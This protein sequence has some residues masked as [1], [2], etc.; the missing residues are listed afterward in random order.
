MRTEQVQEV[1]NE[2]LS[3]KE[4]EEELLK[5]IKGKKEPFKLVLQQSIDY[6]SRKTP[7]RSIST[8]FSR[9]IVSHVT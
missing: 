8:V 3:M 4:T 1:M 5:T 6:W 7:L 9:A 2:I